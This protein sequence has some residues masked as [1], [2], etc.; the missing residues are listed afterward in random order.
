MRKRIVLGCAALWSGAGFLA[1]MGDD[2][3]GVPPSA[4]AG[5]DAT[6]ADAHPP[7]TDSGP[8]SDAGSD[9]AT[10]D[11]DAAAPPKPPYLLLSYSYDNFSKT[12]YSAF[13]LTT[14]AIA[15]GLQYAKYGT[16]MSGGQSPWVLNQAADVVMKMDATSPWKVVSQWNVALPKQND[17]GMPNA[18]P[19]SVAETST[20]AYVAFYNRNT[21][22]VLDTTQ[23]ADGGA[24][25]KLIDVS[26]LLQSDDSDGYVELTSAVYV[27]AHNRV[28]VVLGNIDLN[29]TDPKG[30]FLLC[31][32]TKSAVAAIDVTTDT[33]ASFGDAGVDGSAGAFTIPLQGVSPAPGTLVY[34]AK[35]DRLL[36]MSQGCN[37]P[38]PDDAGADAGKGPLK[39]RLIEQVSLADGTTKL[40]YDATSAGFPA[41][42]VYA[43]EHHAW[44]QMGGVTSAWDPASTSL[45]AAITNAPD[46]FVY[47]GKG[48]LVGPRSNYLADGGFGGID[49]IAVQT[50]DGGVTTL[51][52]SPVSKPDPNGYF[53]GIDL[54]PH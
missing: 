11:A 36:V 46:S 8:L 39:G 49:V 9:T 22:A 38:L 25:A 33:L 50:A 45:G 20:K 40:L 48:S 2:V 26:S 1:C 47:D 3:T 37:E 14:G 7:V 29:K 35:N 31:A 5:R 15:G 30:Y 54:W 32:N 28:Y 51:G 6:N 10:E 17:A 43:D 52:P 24:P 42:L 18:N 21:I 13:S 44:V 23:P 19:W 4:D 27:P 16:N 53:E 41:L 34:D 12:E